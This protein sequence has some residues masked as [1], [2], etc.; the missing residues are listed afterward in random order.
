[1]EVSDS[2]CKV[3]D[4][5]LKVTDLRSQPSYLISKVSDLPFKMLPHEVCAHIV[6]VLIFIVVCPSCHVRRQLL[7]NAIMIFLRWAVT[8]QV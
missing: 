7:E 5:R 4:L 3:A 1:M 2:R 8:Y 6:R